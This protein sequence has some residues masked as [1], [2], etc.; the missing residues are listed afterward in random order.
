M[1][2]LCKPVIY[3]PISAYANKHS[4]CNL[5]N[6]WL[7]LAKA[8]LCSMRCA[9]VTRY[10][11]ENC[12]PCS[13]VEW[14]SRFMHQVQYSC[15]FFCASITMINVFSDKNWWLSILLWKHMEENILI[16]YVSC[17][18][19]LGPIS[20]PH[21]KVSF[22]LL[23]FQCS[24]SLSPQLMSFNSCC[25]SGQAFKHQPHYPHTFLS[26]VRWYM[27]PSTKTQMICF[28]SSIKKYMVRIWL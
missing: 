18:L 2:Q 21:M 27:Y 5:L 19:V 26:C 10:W 1:T 14:T 24:Y 12:R 9:C 8:F 28:L 25:T 11:L 15:P 22:P 4:V 13:E 7:A 16:W 23:P 17:L 20:N 3:G 6:C